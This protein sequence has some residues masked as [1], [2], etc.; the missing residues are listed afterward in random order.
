[1]SDPKND[2]SAAS[3][4]SMGAGG[5]RAHDSAEPAWEDDAASDAAVSEETDPRLGR[6][7]VVF[8]TISVVIGMIGIGVHVGF[9]AQMLFPEVRERQFGFELPDPPAIVRN[10]VLLQSVLLVLLGA[11]LVAGSAM[12]LRR[13]ALGSKLCLAWSVA[14]VALVAAN[15]AVGLKAYEQ[16][17]GWSKDLAQAMRDGR[18]KQGVEESAL[19]PIPTDQ[20]T[21]SALTR[22]L[23]VISFA[24][25][26]WPCVLLI[27][28]TRRHVREEVLGWR[29]RA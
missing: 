20:A 12:L 22:Q 3:D 2:P 14:R 27:V 17:V 26:T 19:Q 8:P 23:T 13:N 9:A 1:M 10:W 15:I 7:R 21:R 28:L 5:A 11:M 6:W 4:P 24:S 25:A 29:R 16:Q 18:L